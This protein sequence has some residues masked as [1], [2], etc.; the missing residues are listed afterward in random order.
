MKSLCVLFI[1]VFFTNLCVS[2]QN[3]ETIILRP[4]PE[5]GFDAEVRTDMNYPIWLD[6]DFISNAWTVGGNSFVQ[7]SLLK[8]DLASIPIGSE[9]TSAR[10]T[11]F[12]NTTSGHHQLHYGYNTSYLL[13]ITSDWNQR[14]VVWDSQ[15]TTTLENAV[16]LPQSQYQT[17]DYTDIDL[18]A[19]I[20]FYYKNPALNFGFMLQL[21]EE[22][23][24][25]A[26]VFASSNHVNP[27][28]RPLLVIEY[29]PC[30]KPDTSFAYTWVED[31]TTVNFSVNQD[32][33]TDYWWDFGNGYYS[34]L[35][36]PVFTFQQ[37]GK[38]NVCLMVS[39]DCDTLINCDTVNVCNSPV[40]E[41]SYQTDG[42]M[43]SF[44]PF[45][46]EDGNQYLWDFGDGFMSNLVQP[47]HF[48]NSTGQYLVCLTVSNSCASIQLCDTI[49]LNAIGAVD[50]QSENGVKIYPNP[51]NG[52]FNISSGNGSI[53]FRNLLVFSTDKK[54]VHKIDIP[55]ELNNSGL[56][57]CDLSVLE[58]GVYLIQMETNI[59]LIY[60]KI[61]LLSNN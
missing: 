41:F 56:I 12:C 29:I 1:F 19:P 6:D 16:I 51:S 30:E 23:I 49:K 31:Q 43:V 25:A 38:Y 2:S 45:E 3:T 14:Q 58:E 26:L 27:E 42:N 34:D 9:I 10:L 40:S 48:Y 4:G 8:F 59:G 32:D 36:Q 46:I 50:L 35:P 13:R 18:T 39:N 47:D 28:K 15:P 53:E 37:A 57:Q 60:R 20:D 33:K 44:L 54:L 61:V 22:Q 5:D 52:R 24:Y 55:F 21:V 7:R 11:L 17:Q